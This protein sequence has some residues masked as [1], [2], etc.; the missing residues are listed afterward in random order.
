M[1]YDVLVY[2]VILII[3]A[4]LVYRTI[5]TKSLNI[6]P[7]LI[8]GGIVILLGAL[9]LVKIPSTLPLSIANDRNKYL[10]IKGAICDTGTIYSL[11]DIDKYEKEAFEYAL[12]ANNVDYD[13]IDVN[14]IVDGK[15]CTLDV[16][17]RYDNKHL[18]LKEKVIYKYSCSYKILDESRLE[19]ITSDSEINSVTFGLFDGLYF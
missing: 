16:E 11:E 2:L 4:N 15:L 3:I 14:K 8:I 12:E 18:L 1:Y 6:N 10:Q 9:L 7:K 19:Y 13:Y 5:K 17:F